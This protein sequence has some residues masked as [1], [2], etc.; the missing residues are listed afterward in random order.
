MKKHRRRQ[1]LKIIDA[2]TKEESEY[3][4]KLF[5]LNASTL[6]STQILLNS[7]SKRFPN[8]MGNDSG[9]LG[10]YLMDHHFGAGASAEVEGFDDIIEYGRRP[11]GFYIPRYR[12][13]GNDKRDYLRGFGYERG[14]KKDSQP[15]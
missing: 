5:F 2:K 10:H 1:G 3:Q 6:A 13:I 15:L 7:K 4:A 11:N 8:G 9:V 14:F 12:N